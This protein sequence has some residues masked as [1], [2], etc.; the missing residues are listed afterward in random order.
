MPDI[1]IHCPIF[2]RPVSTGLT[3]DMI[4]LDTL[5]ITLTTRCPACRKIH[6]WKRKDAWPDHDLSDAG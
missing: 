4:K 6:Q 2:K 3:T 1:M 5:E